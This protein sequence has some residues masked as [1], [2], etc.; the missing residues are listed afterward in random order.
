M[1]Y[2]KN[3]YEKLIFLLGFFSAL[4][5]FFIPYKPF[6]YINR[7]QIDNVW[8]YKQILY[9]GYTASLGLALPFV[10]TFLVIF[11]CFAFFSLK[12]EKENFNLI[13]LG[14]LPVILNTLVLFF[15]S[16]S[17][18]S[19]GASASL[20]GL[21]IIIILMNNLDFK[22]F[23][24]GFLISL[25]FFVNLHAISL[26]LSGIEIS[27]S[28]N[29]I[30]IFGVEI[31]Q[32]LVS[33]VYVVSFFFGTLILKKKL[34]INLINFENKKINLILY[35]ITLTSCFI[36]IVI[37]QRRFA[38]LILLF[39]LIIFLIIYL[40]KNKIKLFKQIFFTAFFFL[41][42]Y[43]F[44]NKFFVGKRAINYIEMIQPRLS[45]I[46]NSL[47]EIFYYSSNN[48][49][50]G[51]FNDWGNIESGF[52]NLLLNTGVV[53]LLSYL[54]TFAILIYMMSQKLNILTL[55]KNIFYIF[56]SFCVLFF[57]NI[58]NNSISTPYFFISFFIIFVTVLIKKNIHD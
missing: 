34:L 39:S 17:V 4:P 3:Y 38:F 44:I 43:I 51:K 57:S 32:S 21:L 14:G 6:I 19:F 30:S 13:I 31:Y 7:Y 1:G 25:I 47:S 33:Y 42:I 26:L 27:H 23:Y 56:F 18:K 5:F 37:M 52:I 9:P 49:Y 45:G 58:I 11:F 36:I 16:L 40:K 22:I 15:L 24:R 20:L 55:K 53:G 12:K 8:I 35:Y 10:L 41:S 48:F 50:F 29:G 46:F 28:I 2:L 54:I